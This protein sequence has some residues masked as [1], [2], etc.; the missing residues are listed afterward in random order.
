MSLMY[1]EEM[2]R[3][4][5]EFEKEYNSYSV[6]E[7]FDESKETPFDYLLRLKNEK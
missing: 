7:E 3:K 1:H 2:L 4:D 6:A 5:E